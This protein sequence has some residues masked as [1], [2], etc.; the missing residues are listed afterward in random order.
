MHRGFSA[1]WLWLALLSVFGHDLLPEVHRHAHLRADVRVAAQAPAWDD[2]REEEPLQAPA[3]ARADD[4][5]LCVHLASLCP[6]L[7]TSA[8]VLAGFRQAAP[9]LPRVFAL[10]PLPPPAWLLA[11]PR[12][13]PPSSLLFAAA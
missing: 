7:P 5:A 1:V 10:A 4:C 8:P 12:A 11:A 2:A 13:P 6:A 9:A 3:G